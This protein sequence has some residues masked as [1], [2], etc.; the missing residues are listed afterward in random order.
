[1]LSIKRRFNLLLNNTHPL[2]PPLEKGIKGGVYFYI[3]ENNHQNKINMTLQVTLSYSYKDNTLFS[4]CTKKKL[5]C[6]PATGYKKILASF[7][8]RR[9]PSELHLVIKKKC[10]HG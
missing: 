3:K 9:I 4:Y 6:I 10:I 8:D 5:L 7:P 1:M 2:C